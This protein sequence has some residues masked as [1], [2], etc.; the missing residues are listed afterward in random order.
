[1]TYQL[2]TYTDDGDLGRKLEEWKR[3][4]DLARPHGAHRGKT[5]YEVLRERLP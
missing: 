2:L 3:F 4:D 5:P 1:V